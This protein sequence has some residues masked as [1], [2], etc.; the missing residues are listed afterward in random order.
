LR[1]LDFHGE[2]LRLIDAE[3]ARV[4]LRRAEVK[5]VMTIPGV[6]VTVAL[7]LVAAVGDFER[8]RSPQRLVSIPWVARSCPRRHSRIIPD[9]AMSPEF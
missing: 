5:R 8:F 9:G 3:L 7:S 1:Q 6:D 2:E 4:A